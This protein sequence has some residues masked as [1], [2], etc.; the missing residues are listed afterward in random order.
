MHD[1][2]NDNA[3]PPPYRAHCGFDDAAGS[4]ADAQTQDLINLNEDSNNTPHVSPPSYEATYD[5]ARS[6]TGGP[7]SQASAASPSPVR[8]ITG[9]TANASY[10][11]DKN[12][13]W[14]PFQSMVNGG[15]SF[16]SAAPSSSSLDCG[17][18]AARGCSLTSGPQRCCSCFDKREVRAGGRYPVYIDGLG[19]KYGSTTRWAHYCTPCQVAERAN[20]AYYSGKKGGPS[21]EVEQPD[22][23]ELRRARREARR[24]AEIQR[25]SRAKAKNAVE[26]EREQSRR[27]HERELEEKER[28]R[29]VQLRSQAAKQRYYE[30]NSEYYMTHTKKN[31]RRERHAQK[32]A[33]QEQAADERAAKEREEA[34]QQRKD[35]SAELTVL[36]ELRKQIIKQAEDLEVQLAGK[37]ARIVQLDQQIRLL[38][39]RPVPAQKSPAAPTQS[40]AATKLKPGFAN[41]SASDRAALAEK[42]ALAETYGMAQQDHPRGGGGGV[43]NAY[44]LSRQS[45]AV[46]AAANMPLLSE[47]TGGSS[48]SAGPSGSTSGG[49]FGSGSGS[50]SGSS[51]NWLGR[52]FGRGKG[53]GKEKEREPAPGES[54]Y[55]ENFYAQKRAEAEARAQVKENLEKGK[56]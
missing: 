51:G 49:G 6:R 26:Q 14:S 35:N 37:R 18:W 41:M 23:T 25:V 40:P 36:R 13:D 10:R 12:R 43:P 55:A 39:P 8:V 38:E 56:K 4:A 17:H 1:D 32:M 44:E 30:Q 11:T 20:H 7:Q 29:M 45:A 50:G 47:K 54:Y 24:Q 2:N 16:S 9:T 42:A 28:R 53:K 21:K 48:S 52:V 22:A 34:E 15:S 5:D 19:D 46:A 3:P 27:Q 33:E 31:E